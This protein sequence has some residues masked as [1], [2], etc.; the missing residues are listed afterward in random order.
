V[1]RARLVGMLVA[2]LLVIG[3]ASV[4]RAADEDPTAVHVRITPY[5]W[6][7]GLYGDVTVRGRDAEV[8]ASFIDIIENS[9]SLVGFRT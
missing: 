3:T 1:I 5:V 2:G 4:A 8:D 7:A 6:A 9:D